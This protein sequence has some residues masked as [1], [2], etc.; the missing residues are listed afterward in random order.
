MKLPPTFWVDRE[1]GAGAGAAHDQIAREQVLWRLIGIV[2]HTAQMR[3]GT[4]SR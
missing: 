2:C 4:R 1:R 3:P